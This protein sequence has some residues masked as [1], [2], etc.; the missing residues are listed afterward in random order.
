MP[1]LHV[2][3]AL[4]PDASSTAEIEQHTT[5]AECRAI[6]FSLP[7]RSC[8]RAQRGD[9]ELLLC[10]DGRILTA[11]D[12]DQATL[13]A[14]GVMDAPAIVVCTR[15]TYSS[16]PVAT[17]T[18]TTPTAAASS[19][20]HHEAQAD[21]DSNSPPADAVCRICFGSAYENGAGKLISPCLCSG[22]MRFVHTSCLDDWRSQSANPRSFYQ[23]DQCN[24]QYNVQRTKWAA[25]LESDR[26]VLATA[27]TLLILATLLAAALLA[28]LGAAERFYRLVA[29][30]PS[31]ASHAG[32]LVASYWCWQL[33]ALVSGLLGVGACGLGIS[34]SKLACARARGWAWALAC[35]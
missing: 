8:R 9:A 35:D 11:S 26:L 12:E 34:V 23:C 20:D 25:I 2:F 10:H 19:N 22:S 28:P 18:D 17:S 4:E 16:A 1:S 24:Y 30:D 7:L 13:G 31:R 6:V 15:S 5:L 14:L 21:S 3:D 27:A 29:F 33:D 32:E